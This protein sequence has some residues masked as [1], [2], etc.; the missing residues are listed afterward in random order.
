MILKRLTCLQHRAPVL[1]R[2]ALARRTLRR[3]L[4]ADKVHPAG[5]GHWH[6]Y[7]VKK[8]RSWLGLKVISVQER[9]VESRV[10]SRMRPGVLG[11]GDQRRYWAPLDLIGRPAPDHDQKARLGF[12]DVGHVEGDFSIG[13]A[14]RASSVSLSAVCT[15]SPQRALQSVWA[16][17]CPVSRAS[18][19]VADPM[20][21]PAPRTTRAVRGCAPR[22]WGGR[23]AAR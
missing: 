4:H 18:K 3:Y 12:G 8:T 11:V 7:V 20:G 13:V 23:L 22:G 1:A 6:Q 9:F 19:F 14:E 5:S 15:E 21:P 17:H 2:A 10:S 16:S